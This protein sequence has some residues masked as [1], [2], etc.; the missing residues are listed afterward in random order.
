MDALQQ[1]GADEDEDARR[2]DGRTDDTHTPE[3]AADGHDTAD[4]EAVRK[5]SEGGLAGWRL[6]TVL[7]WIVTCLASCK[8]S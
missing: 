6:R 7:V 1:E 3:R 8:E 4:G 2:R 5:D